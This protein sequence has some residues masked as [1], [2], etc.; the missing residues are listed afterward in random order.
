MSSE[1]IIPLPLVNQHADTGHT[2]WA[3]RTCALC[4][5]KMLI[6]TQK[7]ELELLSITELIDRGLSLEPYDERYGW[8]HEVLVKLAKQFGIDLQYAQKFFKTPEEKEEGMKIINSNLE[9]GRPIMVSIYYKLNPQ[10]GGHVVVVH[11]YKKDN[12]KILGYHIQDP[13]ES[14]LGHNYFLEKSIFLTNWRGG[15]LWL[16]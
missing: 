6:V 7:P 11:G 10:N 1:I 14:Y 5:L 9:Q 8:R 12:D 3:P 13:A 15:L 16:K 2:Y 4:S